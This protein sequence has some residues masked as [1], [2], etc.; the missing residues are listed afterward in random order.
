MMMFPVTI[1]IAACAGMGAILG[2]IIAL[3]LLALAGAG[4]AALFMRRGEKSIR[5]RQ[6]MEM[7]E[8]KIR[9]LEAENKKYDQIIAG[10]REA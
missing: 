3:G 8:L 5:E 9:L 1:T 6:E 7:M 2:S 4:L 10:K